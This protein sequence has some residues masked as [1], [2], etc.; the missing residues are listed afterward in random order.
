LCKPKK[1]TNKPTRNQ[2]AKLMSAGYRLLGASVLRGLRLGQ[3]RQLSSNKSVL[4]SPPTSNFG[5]GGIKASK[6]KVVCVTGG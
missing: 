5:D 4:L 3:A 1:T 6:V 2:I